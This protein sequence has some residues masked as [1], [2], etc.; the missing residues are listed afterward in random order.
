MDIC[1]EN[2]EACEIYIYSVCVCVFVCKHVFW[3]R[4]CWVEIAV[5]SSMI[6]YPIPS[7]CMVHLPTF[8]RG[9]WRVDVGKHTINI[10]VPWML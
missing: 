8:F 4:C 1:R 6:L 10:P 3:V 2:E 7:I 5:D 9:F